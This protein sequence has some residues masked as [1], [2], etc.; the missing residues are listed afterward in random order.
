ML[1][2]LL[3]QVDRGSLSV[4]V[5]LLEPLILAHDFLDTL[6]TLHVCEGLSEQLL[7]ACRGARPC[8]RPTLSLPARR[9]GVPPGSCSATEEGSPRAS[10]E[11]II[12]AQHSSAP[13]RSRTSPA[14]LAASSTP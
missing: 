5:E 9:H 6:H 12:V 4:R 2:V 1:R 13:C 10:I 7:H 11:H 14:P 3:V 8:P